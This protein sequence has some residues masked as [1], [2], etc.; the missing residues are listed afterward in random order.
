MQACEAMLFD[1]YGTLLISGSGGIGLG[2]RT[3]VPPD[4]LKGLLRRHHIERSPRELAAALQRSI[5]EEHAEGRRQGVDF[6]EVDIL[7]IWKTVLGISDPQ[8]LRAFALEYELSVNPVYPMPG[9]ASLLAACRA[10][11]LPLGLISNAQFYTELLLERFLGSRL[12]DCGFDRGLVFFSYRFRRAKPATFMFERAAA[13]LA[14]RGIPAAS[15]LYVGN[16]MLNDVRPASAVGFKTALFAGDGRSLRPRDAD[17][18][19]RGL[20]PDVVI[21]DLRQ[22]IDGA[23]KT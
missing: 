19:C 4:S 10:R 9:L 18:R 22:L 23:V 3:P 15:A 14:E 13:E 6:P 5:E 1:V 12:E 11:G 7:R 16:D 21:T 8:R 2:R 17:A 20:A